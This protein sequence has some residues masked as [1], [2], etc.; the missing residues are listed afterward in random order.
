MEFKEYGD[1]GVRKPKGN[2]SVFL[3]ACSVYGNGSQ[4]SGGQQQRVF[5]ARALAQ[6]AKVYFMDEP[7]VGVDA[8]TIAQAV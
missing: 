1:V 2:H 7:F 8:Y 6:D 4:L 5:L 3:K